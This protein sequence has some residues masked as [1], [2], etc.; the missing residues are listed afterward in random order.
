MS[1]TLYWMLVHRYVKKKINA[2][3]MIDPT[4]HV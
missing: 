4:I 3:Y 1:S 2:A